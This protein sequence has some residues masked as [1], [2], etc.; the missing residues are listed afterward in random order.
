M[1]NQEIKWTIGMYL[2]YYLVFCFFHFMVYQLQI[3]FYMS[4]RDIFYE[5]F[6]RGD[7]LN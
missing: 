1:S 3:V 5:R 2:R 7:S 4:E 6:H